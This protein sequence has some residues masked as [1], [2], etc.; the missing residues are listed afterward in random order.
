MV[1]SKSE[2][3][4]A[5]NQV[6]FKETNQK[7]YEG[8]E[9]LDKRLNKDDVSVMKDG[10]NT[11]LHFLCECSDEKCHQRIVI[12]PTKFKSLHGTPAQFVILPGHEVKAIERVTKKTKNYAVVEKFE[13]LTGS[14]ERFTR[15]K[16]ENTKK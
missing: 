11:P 3:K 7:V 1:Q 14:P 2:K 6:I 16:L 12:S 15:S 4:L 8:L 13:P 9:N 5:Q 10:L